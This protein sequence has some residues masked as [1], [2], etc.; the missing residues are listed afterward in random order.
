MIELEKIEYVN[1][2]NVKTACVPL[3]GQGFVAVQGENGSGKTA[4]FIEGPFYALYGK[5]IRTDKA[6]GAKLCRRGAKKWAV[7]LTLNNG[8]NR[9]T[10][11]RSRGFKEF[12]SGLAV[13]CNGKDLAR[14]TDD[15]TQEFIVRD[16]IG[17]SPLASKNCLFYTSE[18]L[19]FPSLADGKKKEIFDNLLQLDAI[20]RALAFTK[21]KISEKTALAAVLDASLQR[22][23]N[24]RVLAEQLKEQAERSSVDWQKAHEHRVESAQLALTNA[25][26]EASLQEHDTGAQ[27]Q[28]L[29]GLR[30]RHK[31][32][33]QALE[34]L[35]TTHDEAETAW[36]TV[37][38]DSRASAAKWEERIAS[39]RREVSRLEGLL[40]SAEGVCRTCGQSIPAHDFLAQIEEAKEALSSAESQQKSEANDIQ[41]RVE[42][43]QAAL[44]SAVNAKTPHAELK[45]ELSSQ[46]AATNAKLQMM[47]AANARRLVLVEEAKQRLAD[48][49]AEQNT[50]LPQIEKRRMD[51]EKAVQAFACAEL[52][53]TQLDDELRSEKSMELLFGNK[54]CRV[55]MLRQAIPHL[56]KQAEEFRRLM[57]TELQVQFK[58]NEANEAFSGA[59]SVNVD[60]PKGAESYEWDSRG[61][62][63][64]ADVILLLSLLD[65]A[66]AR[67]KQ[68][69]G[70]A[71][72]DEPFESL[73]PQGLESMTRVIK[74][75][76]KNNS[77]V[78]VVVHLAHDMTGKADKLWTVKDG[79]LFM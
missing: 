41:K 36:R 18:V 34:S 24:E 64:R 5:S 15:A 45:S 31:E 44:S 11:R 10:I 43:A 33:E 46:I 4:M 57:D 70:Q 2:F 63:R 1:F 51:I 28:T 58:I 42:A 14:G 59:L 6:V 30:D 68:S 71:F 13:L 65:L 76:A 78:F 17:L 48:A 20:E 54:G 22:H 49:N 23:E 66:H 35:R 75:I 38:G 50:F 72:F 27:L 67:G 62:R 7:Q 74:H 53:R 21:A 26:K 9:Y 39:A 19:E 25:Q 32:A 79:T 69:V 37:A 56:N 40:A 60:N 29:Q 12:P 52:Q 47:E 77:S 55:D 73:D 16:L 3:A 61:E 8:S